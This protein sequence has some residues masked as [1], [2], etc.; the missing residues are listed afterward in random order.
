MLIKND[1]DPPMVWKLG[2][3]PK[4]FP[5]KDNIAQVAT[6]MTNNGVVKRSFSKICPL[7][8]EV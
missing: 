4:I 7:P 3:V 8:I 5:G 6:I 1:N 2:R